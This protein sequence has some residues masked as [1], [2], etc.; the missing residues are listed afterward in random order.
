MNPGP[1]VDLPRE[2][3][4]TAPARHDLDATLVRMLAD[5]RFE[6]VATLAIDAYGAELHGFLIHAMGNRAEA[7][8]VFSDVVEKFWRELPRFAARCSM[9][10]WLYLL[11]KHTMVSYRRSPWN[12]ARRT[13][14]TRI[15]AAIDHARSQT[16]PWQCTDVKDRWRAI[17]DTIAS[18][19]RALLVLRIDRGMEWR[20]IAR[21][22]LGELEPEPGALARETARLRKRFELLKKQ[23][24][25][26]A[27]AAGLLN[28]AG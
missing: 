13:G 2:P 25:V 9:R 14:D 28:D 12:G 7:G 11:A 22:T 21:V 19:D 20:D 5:G 3:A 18:D 17:R 4:A 15:D 16:P 24:R 1:P 8:D 26:R 27:R 23:L 6:Q 10:T